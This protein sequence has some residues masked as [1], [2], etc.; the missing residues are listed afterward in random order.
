MNKIAFL[1]IHACT[2]CTCIHVCCLNSHANTEKKKKLQESLDNECLPE[3]SLVV[4][5][6]IFIREYT[7]TM[8]NYVSY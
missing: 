4:A 3:V 5:C 6:I 1:D 8:H 2:S 7:Y